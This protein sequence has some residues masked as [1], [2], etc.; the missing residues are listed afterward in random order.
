M[1]GYW[2]IGRLNMATPPAITM[3]SD[4]TIAKIGRS[5]KK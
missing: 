2:E 3:T 5:M 4:T 1:S